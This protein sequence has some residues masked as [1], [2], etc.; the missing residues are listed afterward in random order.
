M[1][2]DESR[3]SFPQRRLLL[4]MP[5][6]RLQFALDKLRNLLGIRFRGRK[7][8]DRLENI[9]AQFNPVA[10]IPEFIF[11]ANRVELSA[12]NRVF[13]PDRKPHTEGKQ[14]SRNQ[15]L[16]H[17]LLR[18]GKKFWQFL[19]VRL[20]KHNHL[21]Q[22]CLRTDEFG[23][24]NRLE[25]GD[26]GDIAQ[27]EGGGSGPAPGPDNPYTDY[28]ADMAVALRYQDYMD[29]WL[30][31]HSYRD[32]ALAKLLEPARLNVL[33]RYPRQCAAAHSCLSRLHRGE[34]QNCTDIEQMSS[35]WGQVMAEIFDFCRGSHGEQLRALGDATGRL[36][37]LLDAWEDL[38]H[39]QRTGAYTPLA[40]LADSPDFESDCRALLDRQRQL[41]LDALDK[42]PL[43]T[44]CALAERLLLSLAAPRPNPAAHRR[45][46]SRRAV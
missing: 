2:L 27:G 41:A 16:D 23:F 42:L 4:V 26:V 34:Q 37:Y 10:H 28:V 45:P 35:Y 29:N 3:D 44:D 43:R 38:P 11:K 20:G 8:L 40:P 30:D 6:I 1:F 25:V 5:I 14:Q 22:F 18:F 31:D 46:V 12:R 17:I 32:L 36:F 15:L 24:I 9:L 7:R 19:G 13:F 39:D 33:Q 21:V